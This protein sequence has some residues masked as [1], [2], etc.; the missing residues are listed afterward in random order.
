[1]PSDIT[2]SEY[3]IQIYRNVVA[4]DGFASVITDITE[5]AIAR[6][7]NGYDSLQLSLRYGTEGSEFLVPDAVVRVFRQNAL[8]GIPSTLEFEGL[9]VKTTLV[10]GQVSILTIDAFGFEHILARRIIAWKDTSRGKTLFPEA[11]TAGF[12][13][14][15]SIIR[16]LMETNLGIR[17]IS[18]RENITDLVGTG[19][20]INGTLGSGAGSFE[21]ITTANFGNAISSI[22]GIAR[23]NLLETI[24]DI[25]SEGAI[26]FA[27]TW[28]PTSRRFQFV[29][30]QNRVGADRTQ[31][32][33][34][35]IGTSTVA[36]IETV[37]DYT[38]IWTVAM[39]SG[40]GTGASEKRFVYPSGAARGSG[41]GQREVFLTSATGTA[42]GNRA[43]A[44]A[45]Y[46]KMQRSI[47]SVLCEV[48][49]SQGLMYG[50]DYFLSDLVRIETG[51]GIVDIQ[52]RSVTLAMSSDG[53]ETIGV[54]LESE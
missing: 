30:A 33:R 13:Y 45:E 42:N 7:V 3:T 35:S 10:E 23:Q 8:L 17:A 4:I 49:Q 11:P 24:Q 52:V 12:E 37:R 21:N 51:Y 26:G 28:N 36:R 27:V 41:I 9:V 5:L 16:K 32:V 29:M 48:Q 50:R 38:Q 39:M 34:F 25:A 14:A 2:S 44:V 22:D 15:S 40:G 43:T 53:I 18:T 47:T 20:Y 31:T 54:T 1:M 6:T 46:N 19:R